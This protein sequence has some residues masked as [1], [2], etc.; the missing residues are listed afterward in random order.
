MPPSSCLC[1]PS[2]GITGVYLHDQSFLNYILV[3][4]PVIAICTVTL[5]ESNV[6]SPPSLKFLIKET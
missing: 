3:A 2:A 1:L 5:L 4:I 6:N